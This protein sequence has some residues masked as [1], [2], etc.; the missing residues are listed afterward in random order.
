MV[1]GGWIQ[2]DEA[3]P[4]YTAIIDQMTLGHQYL[5]E[6]FGVRPTIAWQIDPFGHGGVTPQLFAEMGFD[7]LVI[8]RVHHRIKTMM[9]NDQALEFVW[10]FG[11]TSCDD[12]SCQL[13]THTLHTHYAA[14][15]GFDFEDRGIPAIDETNKQMRA[16]LFVENIRKRANA[17]RTSFIMVPFGDDF[18]FQQAG[19]QFSNMDRLISISTY[20]FFKKNSTNLF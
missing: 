11:N 2:N 4:T 16:D 17:Y 7:A 3:L 8:N 12:N 18:K 9:K 13:F 14:V 6:R 15:Q 1:G 20:F 19:H 10:K 5:L